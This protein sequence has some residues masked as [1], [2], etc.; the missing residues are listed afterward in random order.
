M[1]IWVNRNHSDAERRPRVYAGD[2]FVLPS[3]DASLELCQLAREMLKQAFAPHD[4][5]TAQFHFAVEEYAAILAELKPAFIH[6]PECKR[7]LPQI[8]ATAGCDPRETYFDVPRLRT[9]TSDG[10]LTSGIAY[11]FHPHRDTWYSAPQCQINWW[12][13]V[14]D[15]LPEN[16]ME[17]FPRYFSE[18][19]K[20]GSCDYNYYVWNRDNR[21]QAAQ[22][23]KKDT[24]RQPRPEETLDI[25]HPLRLVPMVGE[26]IVFSGAQLHASVENSSGVARFSI[27]F[28]TVNR[29]DLKQDRGTPNIDSECTGT[30]L[31][32]FLNC[33]DLGRLDEGLVALYD[34]D[35][36]PADA[37]KVF[38][39]T[40]ASRESLAVPKP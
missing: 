3:S 28:R 5:E 20:N 36:G 4:P 1:N 8:L 27:D 19:V 38:D 17:F 7:L 25:T 21:A 12:I 18:P 22:H 24:R 39:P 2:I 33:S 34:R 10:Y 16:G 13:P 35:G 29:R 6:H 15:V 40:Q 23:V 14:Y 11:A 9:S 26:I 32:D 37:P 30:T 31:R